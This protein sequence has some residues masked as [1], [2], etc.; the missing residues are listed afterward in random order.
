MPLWVVRPAGRHPRLPLP[1]G[2]ALPRSLR[3]P[4]ISR[5]SSWV[6]LP[7]PAPEPELGLLLGSL[8]WRMF[9]RSSRVRAPWTRREPLAS[10]APWIP[11]WTLGLPGHRRG[12]D[13]GLLHHQAQP[14]LLSGSSRVQAR[15]FGNIECASR[16]ESSV[17]LALRGFL[18]EQASKPLVGSGGGTPLCSERQCGWVPGPWRK[19][20]TLSP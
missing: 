1:P 11:E 16:T 15:E 7:P 14:H 17:P 20:W 2:C 12:Q 6:S 9:P 19:C 10:P 8:A 4:L 18:S 5:Q 13:Y 3:G